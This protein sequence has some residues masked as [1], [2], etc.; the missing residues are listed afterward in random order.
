M[1]SA[2]YLTVSEAT[3][4][5]QYI[6]ISEFDAVEFW[7]G[8]T[9]D[10]KLRVIRIGTNKLEN[11]MIVGPK[12]SR[13]Q[14]LQFPRF[15]KGR[16]IEVPDVWKEGT[17]M[18]GL[19]MFAEQSSNEL[20]LLNKGIKKYDIEGASITFSDNAVRTIKDSD[21]VYVTVKELIKNYVY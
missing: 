7:D 15:Y 1:I 13:T 2:T 6:S 17:L 10:E 3:E 9:D 11:L 20:S 21:G 5:I 18:Q 19:L 12:F 4:I 16:E 8:L 14:P